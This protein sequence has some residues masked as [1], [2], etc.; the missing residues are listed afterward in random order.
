[1]FESS[2]YDVSRSHPS[3]WFLRQDLQ[4][5]PVSP[6]PET[7]VQPGQE[8]TH[9]R[10]SCWPSQKTL[11]YDMKCFK[12]GLKNKKSSDLII[13]TEQVL[14]FTYF[15]TKK[16]LRKLFSGHENIPLEIL[17]AESEEKQNLESLFL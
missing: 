2:V 15:E 14:L 11:E 8:W 12:T 5:V 13:A 17:S 4:E 16:W 6:E 3:V 1:M 10:V 9:A 7:S